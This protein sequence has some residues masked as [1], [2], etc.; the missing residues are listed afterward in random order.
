M[1][2]VA[3]LLLQSLTHTN[4]ETNKI[5]YALP[6]IYAV[7]ISLERPHIQRSAAA[8]LLYLSHVKKIG[9]FF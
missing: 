9:Q 7:P 6:L 2:T 3:M 5:L 8:Y 4:K 1:P